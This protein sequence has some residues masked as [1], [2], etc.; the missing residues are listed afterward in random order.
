MKKLTM[1]LL[2]AVAAHGAW[3]Q[4]VTAEEMM[5]LDDM[6]AKYKAAGKEL[7]PEDEAR[8]LQRVRAIKA[9]VPGGGGQPMVAPALAQPA[10]PVV[11]PPAA[12]AAVSESDLRQR[13]RGVQQHDRAVGEVVFLKDGITFDGQSPSVRSG[14]GSSTALFCESGGV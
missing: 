2:C 5:M 6:R 9:L 11:A 13:L 12:V 4:S 14:I 1:A 7:S 3:A 8:I 10:S